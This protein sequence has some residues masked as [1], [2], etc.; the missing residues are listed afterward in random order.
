[1]LERQSVLPSVR[2]KEEDKGI[3]LWNNIC[4]LILIYLPF[5]MFVFH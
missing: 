2:N 3:D 4:N 5:S 1:M